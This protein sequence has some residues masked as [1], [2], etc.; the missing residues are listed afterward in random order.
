V[1]SFV[2]GFRLLVV[3]WRSGQIPEQTIGASFVLG[4][5]L[6]GPAARA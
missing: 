5:G 6:A 1:T 2:V 3:G 4:V